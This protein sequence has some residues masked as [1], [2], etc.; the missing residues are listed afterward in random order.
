MK[1]TEVTFQVFQSL[2]EVKEILLSN[3]FELIEIYGLDDWY[4]SRLAEVENLDYKTLIANSFL[5]RDIITNEHN[6]QICYKNKI[7]DDDGCVILEEKT[8]TKIDN[9]E[10]AIS[11][12]EQANLNNWCKMKTKQYVF[13]KG[14][15]EF[16]VQDVEGLG[17]F[18]E[19]EEDET[20]RDLDV[21]QKI[22]LMTTR[23]KNLNLKIGNDFSCKKVFMKLH[24][25]D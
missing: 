4:F 9:L 6:P 18:I 22:D 19:Y 23:L 10:Y 1:E 13:K 14:E 3:K 17:V 2:N 25:N 12:F 11:I 15:I 5:V 8:V 21:N 20:M 16:V 7:I 24:K